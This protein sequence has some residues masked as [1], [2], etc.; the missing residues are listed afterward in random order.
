VYLVG[1]Y[2]GKI[3]QSDIYATTDGTK[4][5]VVGKL[6][7]GLR[8]AGVAAAGNNL[9]IA[10]GVSSAGT[11]DTIYSFDTQ[12]QGKI[13]QIGRLPAPVAHAAVFT[14]DG[15]VYV[16][17]G[18]D[19]SDAAVDSVTSVDPATGHTQTLDPLHKAVSDS[20]VAT[21]PAE[22]WMLGGLSGHATDRSTQATL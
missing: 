6:P 16:V 10:G 1:G 20:A 12:G 4:F 14:L 21:S 13:T 7:T 19:A 2:D 22:A 17:G 8:Y 5:R 18:A 9:I 15:T 11:V 3:P